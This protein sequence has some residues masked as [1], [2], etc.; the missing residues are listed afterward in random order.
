M[1][2]MS[3]GVYKGVRV[4]IDVY[5]LKDDGQFSARITLTRRVGGAD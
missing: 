3:E 1:A 4:D 2:A 5:E